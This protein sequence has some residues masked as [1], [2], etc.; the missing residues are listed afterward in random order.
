MKLMQY[1][2][3]AFDGDT[4]KQVSKAYFK[5]AKKQTS[6]KTKTLKIY[7]GSVVED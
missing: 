5:K 4:M 1:R 7:R 2:G 3:V 6:S